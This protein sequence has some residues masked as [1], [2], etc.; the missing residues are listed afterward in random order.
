IGLA[1]IENK[2]V[3]KDLTNN[4][5]LKKHGYK[6]ITYD[7]HDPRGIDNAL[8]Y[9]SSYFKV[10]SSRAIAIKKI[11]TRDI[12]YVTGILGGDTVH[13]LVNHWPSR[14]EG[15][16]QSDPKR[17]TV[18]NANKRMVDSLFKI[19]AD[20]KIIIMGDMNDN[21][22]DESITQVLKASPNSDLKKHGYL[23][24]PWVSIYKSGKGTSVY[25]K[26]WDHFDQIIISEAFLHDK[27][28]H[29]RKAEIF[30]A[31]FIRNEGHGDDA[32]PK[33]SFRGK[34]WNHGYSDHLPVMIHLGN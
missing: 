12:L 6:Y 19:N 26:Q 13:V 16:K 11:G 9:R 32:Y 21:P 25:H 15:I 24:N 14:R 31:A 23:Y 22:T 20:T 2:N 28:L 33:R 17:A 4:P 3:L 30:D 7:G 5:L 29:F 34:Q 8:L 1:E 10:L 27:K 18:A